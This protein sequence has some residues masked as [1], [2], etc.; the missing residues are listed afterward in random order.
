MANGSATPA[1]VTLSIAGDSGGA[2][3]A[4]GAC[5]G[6]LLRGEGTSILLDCGPG[7][8]PNVRS[9]LDTRML[10]GIVI[11]HMHSDHWTDLIALNI[12]LRMEEF[13][14]EPKAP[15]RRIP[16]WLPPG[17]AETAEAVFRALTVNVRGS[18]ADSFRETLDLH[19]YDPDTTIR[20]GAA[21]VTFVGPTKHSTLCY[22]MRVELGGLTIGY[23][24]DTA[25]C[26]EAIAVGQDTDVFLA[27]CS[28]LERGP[29]SETHISAAE[30]GEVAALARCKRLIATHFLRGDEPW[31]AALIERLRRAYAG[32]LN[33]VRPRERY[34]L[35]E[36]ERPPASWP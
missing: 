5:A 12:A 1:E 4:G 34:V 35:T 17:G 25:Y 7:T 20:I 29:L 36:P 8:V 11:S 19:E 9:C 10:D 18:S 30:L 13:T 21:R 32:P 22:G 6:Y 15:A 31:R 3:L 28:L 16:V 14:T 26:P 27:E 23:T 33:L 2:P 24:G